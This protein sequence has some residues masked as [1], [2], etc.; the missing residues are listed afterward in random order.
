MFFVRCYILSV[1]GDKIELSLRASRTGEE[2]I[3][4]EAASKAPVDPEV[5]SVEDLEVGQLI[6][7]YVKASSNVGIFVRSV[8]KS[9][10]VLR[11]FFRKGKIHVARNSKIL[12]VIY[13]FTVILLI[14]I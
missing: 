5:R 13:L 4:D 8:I 6:R 10:I 9:D 7:G 3:K 14:F 1:D 12:V 11:Y 2:V